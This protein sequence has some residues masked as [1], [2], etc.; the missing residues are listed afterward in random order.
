[1]TRLARLLSLSGA[2]QRLLVRAYV[3]L[4]FFRLALWAV[5]IRRLRKLAHSRPATGWNRPPERLSW[6]VRTAARCVPKATCLTRAMALKRLL[7]RAGKTS[8]LEIGVAKDG[9]KLEAHAW[10][11]SQG[12]A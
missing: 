8:R 6:S 5:P 9:A 4:W 1:V 11:T 10:I 12:R 2:K 7:A 3:L